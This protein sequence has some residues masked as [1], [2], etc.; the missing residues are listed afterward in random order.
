[1]PWGQGAGS[2]AGHSWVRRWRRRWRRQSRSGV[3]RTSKH[4]TRHCSQ[5]CVFTRHDVIC[6]GRCSR[7]LHT[8]WGQAVMQQSVP[9][10]AMAPA[11]SDGRY[12][13]GSG[14][15][16]LALCTALTGR[17]WQAHATALLSC[18]LQQLHTQLRCNLHPETQG[19]NVCCSSRRRRRR[20]LAGAGGNCRC[21]RCVMRR[22]RLLA[23]ACH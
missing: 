7:G 12:W 14:H 15:W 21:A 9:A 23:T 19:K 8:L 10:D 3:R 4:C 6:S 13:E 20:P 11:I 2:R 17:P 22:R 18:H 5:R 1:V 16:L